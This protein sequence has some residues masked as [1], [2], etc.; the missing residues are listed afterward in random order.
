MFSPA[1]LVTAKAA[2]I[3]RSAHMVEAVAKLFRIGV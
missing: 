1:I 2:T 3:L